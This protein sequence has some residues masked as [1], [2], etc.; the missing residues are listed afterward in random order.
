MDQELNTNY[1]QKMDGFTDYKAL[2]RKGV[3]FY[4]II[5]TAKEESVDLIVMGTHGRTGLDHALFGSTTEKV[6]GKSPTSVLIVRLP[7]GKFII[8]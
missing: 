4:G 5:K 6:V 2:L 1:I 8:P 7:A 3:P